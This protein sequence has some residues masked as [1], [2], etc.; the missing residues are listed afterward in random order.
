M[1]SGR[2]LEE[3][4][5]GSGVIEVDRERIEVGVQ[6]RVGAGPTGRR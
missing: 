6:E 1:R 4:Q 3:M 2:D 5:R